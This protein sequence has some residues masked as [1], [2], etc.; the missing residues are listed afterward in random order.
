MKSS[1]ASWRSTLAA[2]LNDLGFQDTQ[3][4]P[5]VWR[6]RATRPDGSPYYELCLVYVDDILL[7]SHDPKPSLLQIGA[8]YELKEGSLGP[9]ETYLGAQ[10]YQ[11]SLHDGRKAWG[12]SSVKY[13]KNA[14][15]TVE[16]LLI[17]DGDNYHLKTTAK[18]PLPSSYKPELDTSPELTDSLT[19]RLRQLI[20]ILRWAVELGRVDI[21]YETAILSQYLASPREGHLEAAYHVFAYLKSHTKFSIVFDP[22]SPDLDESAFAQVDIKSWTEFYGDVAEVQKSRHLECPN[23]SGMQSISRVLWMPTTLAMWSPVDAILES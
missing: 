14:V 17:E 12:M 20:G 8:M 6:R 1:G 5:D 18:E 13:V 7:V 23:P 16:N 3:A 11:H 2:T 22:K 4:D 10:L 9:P 15:I 19:S 21:Y